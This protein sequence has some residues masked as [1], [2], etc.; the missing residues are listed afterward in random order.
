[1]RLS[2]VVP[3][4]NEERCIVN[5]VQTIRQYLEK[6]SYDFEILV[7]NDASADRTAELVDEF[8]GNDDAVRLVSYPVNQG[9]GY[10]VNRGFRE[11][12]GDVVLFSDADLSTPIEETEKLLVCLNEGNDM[13]IGSR[14][15]AGSDIQVHQPWYRELSGRIFN[16]VVKLVLLG[17]FNDTQCGFKMF[18]KETCTELFHRQKLRRFS[19][20][21]ELLFLA[22]KQGLKVGEVPVRWINDEDSRVS[23]LRDATR[24]FLDLFRVRLWSIFGRYNKPGITD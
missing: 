23:L 16:K 8:Y 21:A 6:Q 4:Y 14:G 10:A 24:M 12:L 5:S 2:L 15:T 1:M 3:A 17:D 22:K 20:D 19:F 13:V 18:R 7:V 9:K 11:A